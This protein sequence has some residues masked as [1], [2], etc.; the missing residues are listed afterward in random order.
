MDAHAEATAWQFDGFVLDLHARALLHSNGEPAAIGARA[1]DILRVLIERRGGI[2]SKRE[3][4]DA[5][6]P[7][8]AVEENNLTVHIS[9][10]R[11]VLDAGR[12]Q[13]SCIQTIPG[14][15]YR[16]LP[17][18]ARVGEADPIAPAITPVE[19]PL[20][21]T[22]AQQDDHPVSRP[23][24]WRPA[25]WI[26]A[27]CA[28][29][30]PPRLSIVV[31]PFQNLSGDAAQNYL[32]DSITDDLTTELAYIADAR[33]AARGSAY[34]Y[35]G[36]SI[37]IR[38]IGR[39]LGV[40]YVLEGSVRRTGDALQINAQ[41][42]SGET[43]MHLWSDRFDEPI[44]DLAAGQEHVVERMRD[45]LEI[46]LFGLES[47]RSLR[48]RPDN[49]DAFDLML[50]ARALRNLPPASERE[51][52]VLALLERALSLDPS[53]VYANTT[54]A[55]YLIARQPDA[56]W[57]NFDD[58]ERAEQLLNKARAIAPDSESV[59]NTTVW[60]LRSVERCP[61]S[62]EAAQ[63]AIQMAPHRIRAMTGIRNE[64]AMCKTRN[65]FAEEAIELQKEVL[66]LNPR[67]PSKIFRYRHIGWNLVLLG[68]DEDA[69]K[70]LE[71]SLAMNAELER[72]TNWAY[73]LLAAAY[74]RTGRTD[75]ATRALAQADRFWPYDT[76]RGHG[77]NGST[78]PVYA[79]QIRAYQAALRLA[80][81]RDHADEGAD[82]GVPA[83]NVLHSE[84]AGRTPTTAAPGVKTIRT[85]ELVRLLA[86]TKP[87]VLDAMTFSWGKS[88]PGAIG[89]KW[90]GLGGSLAS[91]GQI[92]LREKM[93]ELTGGNV[94]RPI[95]AVGWNSEHWDGRNLALRLVAMGY[96]NVYWY[97]G[98][99]E[100]WEVAEL[101]ET[102]L[103]IAAW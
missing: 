95:V 67:S 69:I 22:P 32:A 73:R 49:P 42:T 10:L 75:E 62:M 76:V 11:R 82:F 29:P 31:L 27:A 23:R 20:V 88:I 66:Q 100:A 3:I 81:E 58:M 56:N 99:R 54:V 50:R 16:F 15:G 34:S 25:G 65:G 93:R 61:E 14:R 74:A 57:G 101:P 96:T 26:A 83:D 6:W 48:E 63:R 43:G 98:G 46:S 97:R 13:G 68:K 60:W 47:A 44:A 41:L 78:S 77:L 8:L 30:T 87:L 2:V 35:K 85:P 52:Q 102:A 86:D 55:Y 89:L 84:F 17:Q 45:Q 18:V 80:G 91:T 7:G 39:E 12:A 33:V 92:R 40:R 90:S 71:Q 70:Y 72:D 79:E 51:N 5:V 21:S 59:L 4:M 37:D 1:F 9:A 38:H 24:R 103:S 64:L 53:S 28:L 94:S 19:D 36:K